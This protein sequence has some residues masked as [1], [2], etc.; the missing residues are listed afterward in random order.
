VATAVKAIDEEFAKK[1]RAPG[2]LP[3][4]LRLEKEAALARARGEG[5]EAGVFVSFGPAPLVITIE[6][7]AFGKSRVAIADKIN[8][9]A[10]GTAR[11]GGARTRVDALLDAERIRR[12]NPKLQHA[13]NVFIGAP[14][15]FSLPPQ[16]EEPIRSVVRAGNWDTAMNL[17]QTQVRAWLEEAGHVQDTGAG[18]IYNAGAALSEEA[19][20]AFEEAMGGRR[21]FQKLEVLQESLAEEI[22]QRYFFPPGLIRLQIAFHPD[23]RIAELFRFAGKAMFKGLEKSGGIGVW[24]LLTEGVLF[25][26]FQRHHARSWFRGSW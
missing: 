6:D 9:S 15:T 10:R 7:E 13:W 20:A 4:T 25:E 21:L 12:G 11:S 2:A 23:G 5:L 26:L 24:E 3:E 22:R 1:A 16:L 19:L 17:L 14:I 8:E 18:E